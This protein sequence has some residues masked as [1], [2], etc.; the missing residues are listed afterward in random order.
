MG[1]ALAHRVSYE[2][3]KGAIP[4]GMQ[5]DHLCRVRSCVNPDH[6]EAVPQATNLERG[7]GFVGQNVRKTHCPRGHQYDS[8]YTRPSGKTERICTTCRRERHQR[9]VANV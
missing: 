4:D 6:L 7:E 1:T 3:Y 9:K 2:I 8:T 5:V